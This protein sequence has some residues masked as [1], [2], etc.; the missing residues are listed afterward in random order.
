MKINKLEEIADASKR[1]VLREIYSSSIMI[2]NCQIDK[3]V[4]LDDKIEIGGYI[5]VPVN[6]DKYG[7]MKDFYAYYRIELDGVTEFRITSRYTFSQFTLVKGEEFY[8]L[9]AFD[10]L[11]IA[12]KDVKLNSITST[13]CKKLDNRAYYDM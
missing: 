6:I 3:L 5:T 13:W 9:E 12:A 8:I 11:E 1:K 2:A 7:F 10:G 4:Y